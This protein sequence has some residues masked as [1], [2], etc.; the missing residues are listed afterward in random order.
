[1][2]Q[3]NICITNRS[4]SN[5]SSEIWDLILSVPIIEI[6]WLEKCTAISLCSKVHLCIWFDVGPLY[7]VS[8]NEIR[9]EI[10]LRRQSLYVSADPG[11][12]YVQPDSKQSQFIVYSI[13]NPDNVKPNCRIRTT[14]IS[15][16]RIESLILQ[17]TTLLNQNR[18]QITLLFKWIF[19]PQ[20]ANVVK[21]RN[22]TEN[23]WRVFLRRR[24]VI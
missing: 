8:R 24:M 21:I 16:P 14:T 23:N 9:T 19:F 22:S 6:M 20:L 12:V 2:L 7:D 10:Y 5:V 1:M 11:Q 13:D 3:T 18:A 17:F 4:N 15:T